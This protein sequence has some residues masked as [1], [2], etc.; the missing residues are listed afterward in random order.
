MKFDDIRQ[1][2]EIKEYYLFRDEKNRSFSSEIQIFDG[3]MERIEWSTLSDHEK[4]ERRKKALFIKSVHKDLYSDLII[5]YEESV[6]ELSI[7][8]MSF[9]DDVSFVIFD[10][11]KMS[12]Q[13]FS[14]FRLKNM[15][16]FEL[17]CIHHKIKLEYSGHVLFDYVTEP[18]FK[19]LEN[20][21]YYEKYQLKTL[22]EKFL[23]V[24][25]LFLKRPY[26]KS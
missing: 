1:I 13:E 15:L 8:V 2:E 10:K 21:V 25:E 16:S 6:I 23:I 9:L 3:L 18:I 4:I 22:R 26:E 20:T 11:E 5:L 7:L 12:D 24:C 14:L 17:Y 19:D